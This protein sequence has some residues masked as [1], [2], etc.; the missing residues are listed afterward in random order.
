MKILLYFSLKLVDMEIKYIFLFYFKQRFFILFYFKQRLFQFYV[1]LDFRFYPL[2]G[3]FMSIK[4]VDY[5]YFQAISSTSVWSFLSL[6]KKVSNLEALRIHIPIWIYSVAYVYHFDKHLQTH[7][8]HFFFLHVCI[9]NS[10]DGTLS[11]CTGMSLTILKIL[12]FV[13]RIKFLHPLLL[14]YNPDTGIKDP[15]FKL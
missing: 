3:F 15:H 5:R 8:V 14:S 7:L 13:F 4:R 12:S 1:F 9:L 6:C 10:T 11:S 2:H